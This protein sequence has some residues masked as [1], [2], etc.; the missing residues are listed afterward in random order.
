M[1]SSIYERIAR[2]YGV[3]EKTVRNEIN[4]AIRLAYIKPNKF[5]KKIQRKGDIPTIDEVIR[6]AVKMTVNKKSRLTPA[7]PIYPLE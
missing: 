1:N 6:Y 7:L 2:K 5:A 4:R 3:S